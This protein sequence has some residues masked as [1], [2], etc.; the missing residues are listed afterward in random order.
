[1]KAAIIPRRKI[2]H[3]RVKIITLAAA[4][5]FLVGG[6][7]YPTTCSAQGYQV[8]PGQVYNYSPQPYPNYHAYT[9]PA[10]VPVGYSAVSPSPR[11]C[12]YKHKHKHKHKYRYGY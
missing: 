5:S 12:K 1:M 4:L 6:T 8:P 7:A 3:D 10:P 2:V 11:P 9:P